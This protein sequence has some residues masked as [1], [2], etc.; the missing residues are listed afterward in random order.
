MAATI[1]ASD[2]VVITLNTKRY[3][4]IIIVKEPIVGLQ[5]LTIIRITLLSRLSQSSI[6]P[7][8]NIKSYVS[9]LK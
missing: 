1:A 4:E 7:I 5:Y 8:R 9:A 3:T 2:S 6:I